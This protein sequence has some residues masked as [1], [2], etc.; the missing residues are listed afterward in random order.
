MCVCCGNFSTLSTKN[1][2]ETSAGH[3]IIQLCSDTTQ[4]SHQIPQVTILQDC[5][6][7]LQTPKQSQVI[8]CAS[9]L[10]LVTQSGLTLCNPMD[11]SP[12]GSS[13]HGNS[14]GN[15]TGVGCH[16]LLQGIFSTQVLSPGLPHCMRI[17]YQLSH[18]GSLRILEW[19][20]YPFSGGSSQPRN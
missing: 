9:D 20:A 1:V 14:P 12:P 8:T 6:H 15:N 3:L 18:Q 11:C 5:P 7:L 4:R 10:C 13:V 19:K 17:L 16:A 2:P